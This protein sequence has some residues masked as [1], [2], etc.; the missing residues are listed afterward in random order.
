MPHRQRFRVCLVFLQRFQ[1]TSTIST[2][3]SSRGDLI[4]DK[5][6]IQYTDTYTLHIVTISFFLK[7]S[8]RADLISDKV[9]YICSYDIFKGLFK[10]EYGHH[11]SDPASTVRGAVNGLIGKS[12]SQER[13]MFRQEPSSISQERTTFRQEPSSG[14]RE[15]ITFRQEPSSGSA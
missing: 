9:I 3:F 4:S 12:C 13:N 15:R 2:T 8:S 7:A 11:V 1:T 6:D 14:S 10:S 5:V